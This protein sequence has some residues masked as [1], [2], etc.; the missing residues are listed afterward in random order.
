MEHFQPPSS[1]WTAVLWFFINDK[2]FEAEKTVKNGKN[3]TCIHMTEI[4]TH[5]MIH[6][7]DV[8]RG[9]DFSNQESLFCSEIHYLP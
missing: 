9:M 2:S 1:L 5:E 4:V 6:W 3:L 7:I 8:N